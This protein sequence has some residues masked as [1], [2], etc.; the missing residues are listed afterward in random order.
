MIINDDDDSD[1]DDGIELLRDQII[2]VDTLSVIT[3]V[4]K[5]AMQ[6]NSKATISIANLLRMVLQDSML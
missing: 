6:A 3:T 1:N 2:T 5:Q 4:L